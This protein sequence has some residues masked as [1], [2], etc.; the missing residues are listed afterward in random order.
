MIDQS[1]ALRAIFPKLFKQIFV[2]CLL[3]YLFNLLGSSLFRVG[4][5]RIVISGLDHANTYRGFRKT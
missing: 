5:F 2:F 3:W 1:L 4:N